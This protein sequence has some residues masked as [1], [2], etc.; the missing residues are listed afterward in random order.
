M[1]WN[2][3]KTGLVQCKQQ[4]LAYAGDKYVTLGKKFNFLQIHIL[5]KFELIGDNYLS[6]ISTLTCLDGVC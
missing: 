1:S 5:D 4:A 2:L 3:F 6:V